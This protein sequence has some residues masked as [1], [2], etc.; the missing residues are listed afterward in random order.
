MIKHKVIVQSGIVHPGAQKP[1]ISVGA[2]IFLLKFYCA[3]SCLW[4][5][6]AQWALCPPEGCVKARRKQGEQAFVSPALA[7]RRVPP[8][9]ALR[10]SAPE[11]SCSGGIRRT[12]EPDG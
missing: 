7:E 6:C 8:S 11:G 3:C 12:P 9:A 4:M 10:H 1:G 2:L 5:H